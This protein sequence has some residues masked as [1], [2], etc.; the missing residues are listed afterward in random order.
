MSKDTLTY[1]TY[2]VVVVKYLLLA[3]SIL[4]SE[5]VFAGKI[6]SQIHELDK[7][8]NG[9]SHLIKLTT[10]EV[11][12]LEYGNKSLLKQIEE[13]LQRKDWLEFTLNSEHDLQ[14]IQVISAPISLV[15]SCHSDD[16]C[17]RN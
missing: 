10:G 3:L 12:F 17:R 2:K 1:F 4:L 8:K 7:G 15:V 9:Q 13:S 6:Q 5:Q 16:V 11:A 14:S